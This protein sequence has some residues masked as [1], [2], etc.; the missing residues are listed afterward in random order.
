[1]FANSIPRGLE[2]ILALFADD[3][4]LRPIKTKVQTFEYSVRIL[5]SG[6]T[7]TLKRSRCTKH[8]NFIISGIGHHVRHQAQW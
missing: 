1:M 6:G 3:G 7:P 2:G 8:A 5:V 4:K